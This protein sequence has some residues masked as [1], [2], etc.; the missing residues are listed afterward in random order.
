MKKSLLLYVVMFGLCPASYA[1]ADWLPNS[2]DVQKWANKPFE[3]YQ[4]YTKKKQE[5]NSDCNQAFETAYQ[6][7]KELGEDIF[8]IE[9]DGVVSS[10]KKIIHYI[11]NSRVAAVVEEGIIITGEE[12][13]V[14]QDVNTVLQVG[15]F[16]FSG[17]SIGIWEKLGISGN[18]KIVSQEKIDSLLKMWGI[19]NG[20]FIKNSCTVENICLYI[21]SADY[22]INEK[23]H[24]NV[25]YKRVGAYT[26]SNQPIKAYEPTKYTVSEIEYRTYLNNK[27][28]ECCIQNDE[29]KAC[30][31]DE[32]RE[33]YKKMADDLDD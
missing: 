16:A 20:H 26:Y 29:I 2:E 3:K 7:R 15:S 19:H 25:I 27:D 23:L 4:E 28:L 17:Q 11:N 21:P 18:E 31:K 10:N 24:S 32:I 14:S 12:N 5:E 30:T 22:A 6:K 8:I 13:N 1:N 9:A 33:I